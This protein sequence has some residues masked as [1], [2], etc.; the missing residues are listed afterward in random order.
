MW[1]RCCAGTPFRGSRS[2]SN[3]G[4]V[5]SDSESTTPVA[6]GAASP[7]RPP[8]HQRSVS[9][10][11]NGDFASSTLNSPFDTQGVP[12]TVPSLQGR[13]NSTHQACDQAGLLLAMTGINNRSGIYAPLF[14]A[15]PRMSE[16][17]QMFASPCDCLREVQA[18]FTGILTV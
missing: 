10:I 14:L 16:V 7:L 6:P 12:R 17:N 3:L 9:T 11:S 4:R 1:Q 2:Y 13:A 15:S 5:L 18:Q 8:I